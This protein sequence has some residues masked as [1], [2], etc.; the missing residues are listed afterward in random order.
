M[1]TQIRNFDD[2]EVTVDDSNL[3]NNAES[4]SIADKSGSADEDPNDEE[5]EN[6]VSDKEQ[7]EVPYTPEEEEARNKFFHVL[8][9]SNVKQVTEFVGVFSEHE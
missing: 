2:D 8:K 9:N 3:D 1:S 5:S 4:D 6:G 7:A